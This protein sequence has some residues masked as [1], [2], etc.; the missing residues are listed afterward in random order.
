MKFLLD[1]NILIPA[2]PTSPTNIEPSTPIVTKLVGMIHATNCDAF[3]HPASVSELQ[4]DN[5]ANRRLL[6]SHLVDKYQILP[7]PPAI[8]ARMAAHVGT[9]PSGSHDEI[10]NKLLA[11]VIGDAVSYLVTND[12]RIHRK[13]L[14]LGIDNR[15]L[16]DTQAIAVINGFMPT[17]VPT[18][19]AVELVP[20]H[21]LNSDD[22]IF[23]G[24]RQDYPG[25]DDWLTKCKR[26]HRYAFVIPHDRLHA[27]VAILK[28]EENELGLSGRILKVCT[29]KISESARGLRYGELLLRALLDFAF[30]N[31]YN[32]VYCTCY[33]KQQSLIAMLRHFGFRVRGRNDNGEI[34][35][36]KTLTPEEDDNVPAEPL[37]YHVRYGPKHFRIVDEIYVVPIQPVFHRALF[38]ELEEQRTL[39]SGQTPFGNSI[40]K[41]YLCHA[42][43]KSLPCGSI[44]LFYRSHDFHNIRAVGIV[45]STIRT[46]EAD[47]VIQFVGQRT[48][49]T[50]SEVREMC[51]RETLAILFR[52]ATSGINLNLTELK[53][54]NALNGPPQSITRVR[55]GGLAWLQQQIVQ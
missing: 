51:R 42:V 52:Q 45:E 12:R 40:R 30:G 20:C 25:F 8:N 15:V 22:P 50:K 29:F 36:A 9:A 39:F 53:L 28:D 21:A 5:D 1:T 37:D 23:D 18:P 35:M 32:Y 4:G 19:P 13:A 47:R 48:V 55:Q 14:R 41:A 24:L 6:R 31:T 3:L 17:V 10:D 16:F 43:N 27:G 38:P 49:Y 46:S 34:V 44:L 26:S 54:A 33:S 11:A 7:A 2:E